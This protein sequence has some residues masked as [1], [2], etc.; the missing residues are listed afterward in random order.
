MWQHNTS[1]DLEPYHHQP[2]SLGL[3]APYLNVLLETFHL[4]CDTQLLTIQFATIA[5]W[6][7]NAWLARISVRAVSGDGIRNDA[8]W[9]AKAAM[10]VILY[11][12]HGQDEVDAYRV[13]R[14]SDI[15]IGLRH[16]TME[17]TR[18]NG[19]HEHEP[20]LVDF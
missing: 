6:E 11:I 8:S 9:D 17:P 10:T 14:D 19:E 12:W 1:W 13:D 16:V 18:N 5:S 2:N 15:D 20:F 3:T 7:D 4:R